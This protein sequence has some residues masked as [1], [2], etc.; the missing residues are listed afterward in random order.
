MCTHSPRVFNASRSVISFKFK[1]RGSNL[2]GIYQNGMKGKVQSS[3]YKKW[4]PLCYRVVDK[5]RDIPVAY[6]KKSQSFRPQVDALANRKNKGFPK[7]YG[8]AWSVD[9]SQTLWINLPFDIFPGV[10]QKLEQAGAKAIL[11]VP[12]WPE[13]IWFRDIMDI[14]IDIV[15]LPDRRV[16]LY[17]KDNGESFT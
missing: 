16:K 11:I 17:C 10:V 8:D 6:S 1:N 2:Q 5:E 4:K 9:W 14:L 12:T 7:F 13:E 3:N 15:E